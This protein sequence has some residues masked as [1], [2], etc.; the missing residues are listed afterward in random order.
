MEATTTHHTTIT[1]TPFAQQVPKW[2]DIAK[3]GIMCELAP[4]DPDWFYTRVASVARQVYFRP[5]SGIG[6]LKKRYGGSYQ[7]VCYVFLYSLSFK[8]QY[9][10][11]LRGL[12]IFLSLFFDTLMTVF[13]AH[14][15]VCAKNPP[16]E[17]KLAR[18]SCIPQT[19]NVNRENS[20][21]G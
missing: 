6:G 5:G 2:V 20:P 14:T 16:K 21:K 10:R 17:V 8:M 15:R 12:L 7:K 9:A 1:I 3:T 13:L 19:R 18:F 11:R 4:Q